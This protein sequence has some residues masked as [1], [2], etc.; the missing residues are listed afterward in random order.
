[1]VIY[2][3]TKLRLDDA[4]VRDGTVR[5]GDGGILVLLDYHVKPFSGNS[6]VEGH[7]ISRCRRHDAEQQYENHKKRE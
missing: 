4:A 7:I 5:A 6:G 3:V 2:A 1:M